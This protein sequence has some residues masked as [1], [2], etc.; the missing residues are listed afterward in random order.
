VNAYW[1]AILAALVFAYAIFSSRLSRTFLTGPII[2]TALGLLI[3]P[4]AL[5][6]VKLSVDPKV[7]KTLLEATLVLVL[8]T[9]AMSVNAKSWRKQAYIPERLLGIG[10]PLT[11][12][13]GFVAALVLF[14][15]LDIWE[16]ALVGAIL[17]PTDAA[18]GLAVI[19]NPRVPLSIRQ[20]LNVESGLNDGIVF[21][22]VML[23]IA[24]TEVATHG[25]TGGQAAWFIVKTI[26]LSGLIGVAVGWLGGKLATVALGRKW[27]DSIW[28]QVGVAA[29]AA[30]AYALAVPFEGSGFISAWVAGFVFGLVVRENVT[31]LKEFPDALG[32]ILVVL[33]FFVFG[34]TIL[35]SALGGL[36]W[37]I[38]LYAAISLTIVRMV[39]VALAMV[40]SNTRWPSLLYMGWF[41]PRGLA[42]I[43]FAGI[44]IEETKLPGTE[45][46]VTIMAV[47]VGL[48]ILLHGVTAWWGSNRYASW[49]E[50]QS[51]LHGEMS[52][53]RTVDVFL[54]RR[55]IMHG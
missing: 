12:A 20:G 30:L 26:V 32:Q 36:T 42:S 10:L 31:D 48:S 44:I 22:I 3:G 24:G 54:P 21:P 47:T 43:V 5:D 2:F 16:A 1:F 18:L 29:L 19:S 50:G 34:N 55:H 25:Q 15:K 52:E 9:D 37:Q 14:G 8:F 4:Q 40:R 13:L 46:I 45:L 51:E 6:M 41:G 7:V 28:L 35:S 33:S 11:I 38:V 39:P 23:L 53:N 27:A 17:A 49:Y